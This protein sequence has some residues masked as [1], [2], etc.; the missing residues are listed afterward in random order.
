MAYNPYKVI[1]AVLVVLVRN[2]E[3]M[4]AK[5][6]GT[7]YMDGWYGIIGG[8]L[9][10]DETL[11]EGAA[12]EVLEEIGVKVD[13][14]RLELFHIYQNQN[15]PGSQYL[16]F[17]FRASDWLGQ[18]ESKEDKVEGLEIFSLHDLPKKLI[19]YHRDVLEHINDAAIS[20]TFTPLGTFDPSGK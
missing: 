9:E 1:P 6:V 16:G 10:E 11:Q 8:H 18:A 2:G 20:I 13:P 14:S 19:P 3:V 12:R 4:L 7:S 17:V 5:R 15:T